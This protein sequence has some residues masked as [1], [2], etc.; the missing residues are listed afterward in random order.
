MS[1]LLSL[2]R[3]MQAKGWRRADLQRAMGANR[4][5]VDRLLDPDHE[6][7]LSVYEAA[8]KALG[9]EADFQVAA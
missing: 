8:L 5:T 1:L 9:V 3:Q 4:T 7:K 6:S 2:Y